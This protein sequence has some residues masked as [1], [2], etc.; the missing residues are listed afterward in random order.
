MRY[1]RKWYVIIL[2]VFVVEIAFESCSVHSRYKKMI[3]RRRSAVSYKHQS[4]YQKKLRKNVLPINKN[5]IIR[6]KR[7]TQGVPRFGVKKR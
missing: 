1:L 4:P 5:Y 3:K 7:N 6:N 2:L